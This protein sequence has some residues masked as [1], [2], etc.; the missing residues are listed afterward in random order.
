MFLEFLLI[1][2]K[3]YNPVSD[4]IIKIDKKI[5]EISSIESDNIRLGMNNNV[6]YD[7]FEDLEFYKGVL[8]DSF[9]GS[10]C[11]P[12]R[13]NIIISKINSLLNKC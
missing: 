11:I 1:D 3:D 10:A 9:C 5:A 12:Y 13:S 8:L 2:K 7:L 4:L 6:N